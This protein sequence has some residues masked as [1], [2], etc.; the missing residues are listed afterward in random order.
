MHNWCRVSFPPWRFITCKWTQCVI[1][2]LRQV[3]GNN[4]KNCLS[5]L[6][7][8]SCRSISYAKLVAE[9]LSSAGSKMWRHLLMRGYCQQ[10][11]WTL[12]PVF[13]CLLDATSSFSQLWCNFSIWP[14]VKPL[15]TL[16]ALCT[17][18][19]RTEVQM[20]SLIYHEPH[21]SFVVFRYLRFDRQAILSSG[22]SYQAG[23]AACYQRGWA[24]AAW[25]EWS[26][27]W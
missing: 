12:I 13:S 6:V 1:Q 26:A 4:T 27:H 16:R 19:D 11:D 15:V 5:L 17:D 23:L 9:L 14:L 8:T 20:L 10:C 3:Y 21:W 25:G 2:Y 24:G 18:Q 7:N 22:L